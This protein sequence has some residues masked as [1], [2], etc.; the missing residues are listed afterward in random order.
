MKPYEARKAM[1]AALWLAQRA[2]VESAD[3]LAL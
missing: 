2:L 1:L 3:L